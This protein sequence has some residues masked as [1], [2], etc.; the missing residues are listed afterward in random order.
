MFCEDD[1]TPKLTSVKPNF[2][3]RV[4]SL[5]DNLTTLLDKVKRKVKLL[6]I[7]KHFQV[8]RSKETFEV[9]LK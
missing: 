6:A 1:E 2:L 7:L 8:S 3:L 9:S 4:K 5:L